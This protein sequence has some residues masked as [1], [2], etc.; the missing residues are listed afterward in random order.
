VLA[1]RFAL[2]S[3]LIPNSLTP[4]SGFDSRERPGFDRFLRGWGLQLCSLQVGLRG[5]QWKDWSHR[6]W[7]NVLL[8]M[9]R[10]GLGRVKIERTMCMNLRFGPW[11]GHSHWHTM[12]EAFLEY[13]RSSSHRCPLF[14][15]LMERIARQRNGGV[16]SSDFGSEE[17]AKGLWDSLPKASY[18]GGIKN[19]VKLNRFFSFCG[20]SREFRPDE[21]TVLLA[22][23]YIGINKGWFSG[24]DDTPLCNASKRVDLDSVVASAEAPTS[25]AAPMASRATTSSASASSRSTMAVAVA[26]ASRADGPS[27]SA[28][29]SASSSAIGAAAAVPPQA[30]TTMKR[31]NEEV[32]KAARKVVSTMLTCLMA[33]ANSTTEKLWA[34]LDE[35]PRPLEEAHSI[36]MTVHKTQA[37]LLRWHSQMA[38]GEF[39]GPLEAMIALVRSPSGC[40]RLGFCDSSEVQD[41][42]SADMAEQTLLAET[43]FKFTRL[44]VAT[45]LQ[46]LR[47][48]CGRPP[49]RF[50][51]LLH[52]SEDTRKAALAWC[53]KLYEDLTYFEKV[54]LEDDWVSDFLAK[55]IWPMNTW[56][57]ETLIG[58]DECNFARIPDDIRQ[59]LEESFRGFGRTIPAE[60]T[61][62]AWSELGDRSSKTKRV[63]RALRWYHALAS[64]V[65]ADNDRKPMEVPQEAKIEAITM[66]KKISNDIFLP[67][68]AQWSL[69]ESHPVQRARTFKTL[70]SQGFEMIPSATSAMLLCG[71][72]V[73]NLKYAYM[74]VL[75]MPGSIIWQSGQQASAAFVLDV[76]HFG[77]L[78]CDIKKVSGTRCFEIDVRQ[79]RHVLITDPSQWLEQPVSVE[80][81]AKAGIAKGI[82]LAARAKQVK[83]KDAAAGR[84]FQG[85]TCGYMSKLI[86]DWKVPYEK[87]KPTLERALVATL[88]GHVLG[89]TLTEAEIN[90]L[91]EIRT[92]KPT[93]PFLSPLTEAVLDDADDVLDESEIKAAKDELKR[94]NAEFAHAE[95]RQA[96][97]GA[98][99]GPKGKKKRAPTLIK[100][101]QFTQLE[102][103]GFLPKVQGCTISLETVWHGRWKVAYPCLHPPNTMH[104]MFEKDGQQR[105]ALFVC[106]RWAWDNHFKATGE[107][108]PWDLSE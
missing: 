83:L 62:G 6:R 20:R 100:G 51:A 26:V 41:P 27:R 74:S 5:E 16:L 87:P 91:M 50:A 33:L 23:L 98:K 28:G 22:L 94:T 105:S 4:I 108:C 8:S 45:E 90:N 60:N 79:W 72:S 32:D 55:L 78:G 99:A 2:T 107:S 66:K 63:G 93:L 77:V 82:I 106:L 40:R 88:A 24:V 68:P 42:E 54:A 36:E 48:L 13:H 46:S 34:F 86:N 95:A 71:R 81:P 70:S 104:G 44:L 17:F 103:K 84:G 37:G 47:T 80:A 38:A 25:S 1:L 18:W 21:G 19:E 43:C 89:K 64:P 31:A 85:V 57:R 97:E 7:N 67:D 73:E 61:F 49:G 15:L 76:N 75:C 12:H 53:K 102:A 35:I 29:D 96:G 3:S 52:E 14:Q 92:A 69:K 65:L 58:L 39:T 101:V 10:A 56:A 59:N 9:H 30:K 11:H